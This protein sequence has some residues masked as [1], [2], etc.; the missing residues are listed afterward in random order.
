MHPKFI[1]LSQRLIAPALRSLLHWNLVNL[2]INGP[3]K[4]SSIYGVAILRERKWLAEILFASQESGCSNEVAIS[5]GG[6][7][8]WGSTVHNIFKYQSV[9]FS[10]VK[11]WTYLWNLECNFD[12][13]LFL[14]ESAFY[15]CPDRL[16]LPLIFYFGHTAAVYV[17]KLVLA[18][19]LKV[20]CVVW[21][22]S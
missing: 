20:R 2:I 12:L 11:N 22:L 16:R 9:I 21:Y 19:L 14:D 1:H 3:Q 7:V 17:N 13:L 18:G 10:W 8:W 6:S 15:K 5:T 4:S